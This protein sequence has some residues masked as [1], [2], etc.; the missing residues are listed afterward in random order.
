MQL[1]SLW[2]SVC[3]APK[4]LLPSATQPVDA[5][6]R[7]PSRRAR[8]ATFARDGAIAF[9]PGT[10]PDAGAAYEASMVISWS[11]RRKAVPQRRNE[12]NAHLGY[13]SG[14]KPIASAS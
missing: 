6:P 8:R 7:A 13:D 14:S 4:G 2:A 11:T 1:L 5:Y 12:A 9:L 3:T 10:S